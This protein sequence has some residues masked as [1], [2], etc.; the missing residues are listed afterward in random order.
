MFVFEQR[1]ENYIEAA[2]VL[3]DHKGQERYSNVLRYGRYNLTVETGYD[4]WDGGLYFHTLS[5]DVPLDIFEAIADELA[6][7][8]QAVK[9]TIN[10]VSNDA[11]NESLESVS[12]G[13][14]MEMTSQK[15]IGKIKSGMRVKTAFDVYEVGEILGQGGNGRVYSAKSS[16]GVAVAIKFLEKDSKE[17]RK[18]FKNEIRFCETCEHPNVVKVLDRGCIEI[19]GEDR[20]FCVMPLYDESLRA[21][22][23]RGVPPDEAISIFIGLIKAL[24]EAHKHGVVHRDVKPENIMFEKGSSRPILCDFGIARIP[25]DIQETTIVTQPTSRMANFAYAAPEQKGGD[26]SKVGLQADLYAAGLILNEMFTGEVPASLGY[27]KISDVVPSY[28]FLDLAVA[29]L[30]QQDPSQRPQ[31]A[32]DVLVDLTV[33]VE[34]NRN[35]ALIKSLSTATKQNSAPKIN[36]RVVAKKYSDSRILFEFTEQVPH[37]W[38]ELL[39]R[40]SF[41][42]TS[43]MD[44]DTNRVARVNDKTLSIPIDYLDNESIIRQK[45]EYFV[46]WVDIVN[47][48]YND[49]IEI[50]EQRARQQKEDERKRE[51]SRLEKE[52]RMRDLIARL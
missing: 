6:T 19:A 5:I 39:N 15:K 43:M 14:D 27:K 45:V 31:S 34:N 33:R 9:D 17:K 35:Q 13:L 3:L 52:N 12:I 30:F 47:A 23:K 18:R 24:D 50:R 40:G 16:A 8:E 51:I 2:I 44:C 25:G 29:G 10:I 49:M 46:S 48:L 42:H 41:S 7:C 20:I 1:L 26:A 36:L 38:L 21:K 4:R 28:G 22:I 32:H 37:E 11:K